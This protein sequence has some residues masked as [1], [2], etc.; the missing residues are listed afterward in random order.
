MQKIN[1]FRNLPIGRKLGFAFGITGLLF[2]S[3]VFQYHLALFGSL[4]SYEYLLEE[5][6]ARKDHF[7]NIHR[8]M[9]DARRS[10]KD[11]LARKD[12][13]YVE[14]AV[15]FVG[16]AQ[17]ETNQLGKLHEPYG[18]ESSTQMA[19]RMRGLLD[20]YVTSF[21]Q[22]VEAWKT[23]G[24]DPESGLQGRFRKAA[25]EM[26]KMLNDYDMAQLKIDLGE[27]RR[28][29]KDFVVRGNSKYVTQ[30]NDRLGSFRAF[31]AS[32]RINAQLK[33]P[34]GHALGEYQAAFEAFVPVRNQDVLKQL[35]EPVYLL[36]SEKARKVEGV[37]NAHY[38]P[39]IWQDLLMMR[40]HEKDYLL[41][42]QE[43]YVKQLREVVAAMLKNVEA[44]SV[45]KE[46]KEAIQGYLREYEG[47]FLALVEQNNRIDGLSEKM[48]EAVHRME[49][50]IE[51]NVAAAIVKSQQ[52]ADKTRADSHFQAVMALV[53]AFLSAI[54][55]IL[56]VFMITRMITG[57]LLTLKLFAQT[58]STGDL[59][60]AVDF[61]Q[62]DEV[63]LLGRA[64]SQ[65]VASLFDLIKQMSR[66]A[67]DLEHSALDLAS[68]ASQVSSSA[69]NMMLQSGTTAAAVEELSATMSQISASSEEANASMHGM[70][71][72]VTQ[73]SNNIQSVAMAAQ[74]T[75]AV[76]SQVAEVSEGVSHQL[77]STADGA[78]RANQSVIS[79]AESIQDVNASFADVRERCAYADTHSMKASEH[80]QSSRN[81]MTQLAQS[82]QE[83][84]AVVDV[85]NSIAEQ[86]NMLALNA[87]IEAA[88]AGDAGKGFAVVANEVKELARQ[89]SHATQMIHNQAFAIQ[90][91][92]GDVVAGI[93]D[94][95]R[96]IEGI[97]LANGEIV[98]AVNAQS[99]AAE[100]VSKAMES[101]AGETSDV[102]QH[103]GGTVAR[104]SESSAQLMQVFARMLEVSNQ[105]GE[106]SQGMLEVSNT[107]QQVALGANDITRSVMEAASA[108]NEVARAMSSVNQ[109]ASQMESVSGVLDQRAGQL[110]GMAKELKELVARFKV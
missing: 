74:E 100:A 56:F 107:V 23:Q 92:S 80:I 8:F 83:I 104:M 27:M 70:A 72:G 93:Q 46:T 9:L 26:E 61:Q 48:R 57:P 98:H 43:K 49:P 53:V 45:S 97:A 31:L 33:E 24:L 58:V 6:D 52:I 68:V 55:A 12:P 102:T 4:D 99:V 65:M 73:V 82:A 37:L 103:L 50:L 109:E 39:A 15:K 11:F 20:T 22:I 25:H 7:L 38:I 88:G 106:A 35:E 84:G 47:S 1:F 79:A 63:G 59:Q 30:F 13:K 78:M 44:S 54:L 96:L 18:S 81:V 110:T 36:M 21:Q 17:E 41:R 16:L 87:S 5:Y 28:H 14:R 91:Q 3:V 66:N 40:R 76:L 29:E 2:M 64:M 75:A 89:T 90:Q 77:S 85:I 10:E 51:E 67:Q 94:V 19:N 108:T 60:V 62:E 42:G 71:S 69:K 32:S 86:T 105:M 95:I 34:L 101:A